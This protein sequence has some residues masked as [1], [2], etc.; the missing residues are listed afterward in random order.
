L[1]ATVFDGDEALRCWREWRSRHELAAAE[2]STSF[3]LPALYLNLSR[4]APQDPDL[5]GL[6]AAH[7]SAYRRTRRA[8]RTAEEVLRLLHGAG[9]TATILKGVPLALFYY[10]DGGARLMQ[11]FDVLIRPW[12]VPAATAAL[13]AGGWAPRVHL[14]PEHLRPFSPACAYARSQRSDVDLHWRPFAIDCPPEVEERFHGRTLSRMALG[15]P[16]RVPDATDLL[17]FTCFHSRKRDTQ[18]ACRWVVDALTIMR[19]ANP[20]IDWDTLLERACEAGFLLPV[21]ETLT[22]LRREFDAPVPEELLRRADRVQTSALDS[23]RYQRLSKPRDL[24][25]LFQLHWGLYSGWC[26][27]RR[28]QAKGG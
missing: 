6:Y 16:V 25:E 12:E 3:I 7:Q 21:R 14:P 13:A 11:D 10:R 24:A 1:R 23:L 17:F 2:G 28:R 20:P 15:V 9:I 4:L 5:P 22:Y 8:L 18:A 19:R 27:A 26:R